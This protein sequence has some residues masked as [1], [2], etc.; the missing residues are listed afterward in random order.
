MNKR[1]KLSEFKHFNKLANEWWSES[2]K[3]KILHKIK[4]IRIKYIL[5]HIG[6]KKT[7]N[8]KILDLGCGGG[9]IC[10]SLAKLGCSVTGVDFVKDNIKAAKLHASQNN[11]NINYY[12]QDIDDLS[13]K[14][15]YDLIILFEVLEHIENWDKTLFK[16]KKFLKKDGLIF[17]STINR[18]IVSNILAI[19]FAENIL[20]W[21]PKKTH[22]YNK[23]ITPDEL[24]KALIKENFSI[25][26]FS[27]L[28]FNPLERKWRLSKD[29]KLVNYF[30]TARLN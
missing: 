21:V 11:L 16:I 30:C 10:E 19:K 18:N 28:V 15:R 23:L 12:T 22:D 17:L 14:D 5:D 13:L 8:L 29:N 9:L 1:T 6:S 2:G 4:P 20:K 24:E 7:K 25:L 27:G 26:D 3:Y